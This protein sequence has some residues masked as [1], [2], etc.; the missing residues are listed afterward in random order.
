MESRK[1]A[2]ESFLWET[3]EESVGKLLERIKG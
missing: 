1:K 2:E 3:R